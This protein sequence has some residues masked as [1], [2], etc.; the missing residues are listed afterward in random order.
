MLFAI[1]CTDKEDGLELRMGAR[2]AHLEHLE[3][4]GDR[5]KLAGPF[6][7]DDGGQPKG[8]LLV[9]EAESIEAARAIADQD[10][11]AHAGVF[12]SVDIR[13]WKLLIN[14]TDGG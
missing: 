7:T 14:N 13:A 5:L 2:P 3:A 8:S 12:Q 6:M 9:V 1:I 10:P 4:L 11:Y